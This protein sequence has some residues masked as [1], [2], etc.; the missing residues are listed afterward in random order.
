MNIRPLLLGAALLAAAPVY[1][2]GFG[3]LQTMHIDGQALRVAETSARILGN[4]NGT[5]PLLV[6]DIFDG[7]GKQKVAGYKLM[8]MSRTS[9]VAAEA[10][11]PREGQTAWGDDRAI[12]RGTKLLLGIPV[13]KGRMDLSRAQLLS[14]AAI[15]DANTG[16][17]FKAEDKVRPRGEQLAKRDAQ[18]SQPS[19]R[20]TALQLPDMVSG[21]RSG[22]GIKLQ[23]A[24]TIN[25]QRVST[26]I[27]STFT[28]FGVAKPGGRGFAADD[29]LLD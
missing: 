10:R 15:T 9:S 2:A 14:M 11:P 28:E 16:A 4:E 20:V 25:G 8:V 1:A 13:N 3:H 23:A 27:N 17:N 29:R 26:E 22:G 5:A 24:A 21:E 6:E 7:K 18:M 19:L 12:H